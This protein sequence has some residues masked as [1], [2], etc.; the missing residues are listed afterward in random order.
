MVA[1]VNVL[2]AARLRLP[3]PVLVI[4]NPELP[5]LMTPAT[6]KVSPATELKVLFAV[7]VTDPAIVLVASDTVPPF[8]IKS[9][10][11]VILIKSRVAP[12]LTVIAF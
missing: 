9:L 12:G 2:L 6:I 7:R 8:R 11:R 4:P 1:P 10:E 3:V 5:S